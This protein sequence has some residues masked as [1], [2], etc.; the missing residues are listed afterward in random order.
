MNGAVAGPILLAVWVPGHPRTKGSKDVKRGR[1]FERPTTVAWQARVA[2][3]VRRWQAGAPPIRK[4]R[5]LGGALT[6]HVPFDDVTVIHAG[7][8]DKHLRL[9]FDALTAGGFWHDDSQANGWGPLWKVT[10]SE[11]YG[12]GLAVVCW[13]WIYP[14]TR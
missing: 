2:H 13:E 14:S 9:V 5:Q 6:L 8:E 11:T 7:D 3:E 12:P 10:A 1:V 4:P